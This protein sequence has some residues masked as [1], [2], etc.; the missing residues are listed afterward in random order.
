MLAALLKQSR[1]G[2]MFAAHA[3]T[4]IFC[5]MSCSV[6][7]IAL[8][9]MASAGGIEAMWLDNAKSESGLYRQLGPIPSD[10]I[11]T[12][13]VVALD[14]AALAGK[15]SLPPLDCAA[16][17]MPVQDYARVMSG[18]TK[19]ALVLVFA[20][21]A[22]IFAVF[23]APAALRRA[24]ARASFEKSAVR[25]REK[26][27]RS[28]NWQA[29]LAPLDSTLKAYG[30][31]I[32][33]SGAHADDCMQAIICAPLIWAKALQSVIRTQNLNNANLNNAKYHW[34]LTGMFDHEYQL[35]WRL[36]SN[37]SRLVFDSPYFDLDEAALFAS[38]KTLA[39]ALD[40]ELLLAES[41][42]ARS[43]V[44][45]HESPLRQHGA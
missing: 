7:L 38:L 6:C 2:L 27:L 14:V 10:S 29:A 39:V 15:P 42:V 32:E 28:V 45:T 31:S 26:Q 24:R 30:G 3:A 35:Q 33:S 41:Q 20:M 19:R 22:G 18:S 12:C 8:L 43:A 17:L 23:F 5:L 11:A 36:F 37:D 34:A 40:R 13:D 44:D 16:K 9:V 21:S 4:S 25:N 1:V